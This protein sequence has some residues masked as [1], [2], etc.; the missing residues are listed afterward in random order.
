VDSLGALLTDLSSA[1]ATGDATRARLAFRAVRG[2]YKRNETLLSAFVPTL[3]A[4]FNGPLPEGSDDRPAPPLSAPAA[5]QI[6]EAA[7]FPGGQ[8]PGVESLR[9]TIA[10]M[11]ETI[12][13]FRSLTTYLDMTDV[14]VLDA[15]RLEL[16]R[17]ACIGLAGVDADLS[18]DAVI[19]SA[20][21]LEGTRAVLRAT[22]ESHRPGVAP[23]AWAAIDSSVAAAA[24]YLRGHPRFD[25]LDRLEFIVRY[26]NPASRALARARAQL[27]APPP[28][29]RLWRQ[30]V[31]TVFDE[32]AFDPSAFA[33]DYAARSSPALVALG[34]RLFDDPRLSGPGTR[35]CAFCHDPVRGFADGK[36]RS[37]LLRSG[38]AHQRNTP[39]LID[40][41]YQPALFADSRAG[42]L[43]T[44]VDLVL[45]SPT[46]MGGSADQAAARL[47]A[48]PS[49]REE[50]ARAF[51]GSD[52]ALTAR[53]LRVAVA[54][55]VRSLNGLNSP[56][57]RAL[58]GD[59]AALSEAAHRGFTLF[60]GKARC[61]TCHFLPLLNGTLPP[62]FVSSEPEIIGVTERPL[63]RH[64]RLDPDPGRGGVDNEPTHRGAF[65]VP[66][67]RNISRTAPYMHNG[68][69]QCLEDVVDFYDRG[70][71]A[72][73]GADVPGQT[74]P[75]RP[76]HLSEGEK[77]DL[78]AFL[79]SLDDSI[80]LP[81]Q[82]SALAGR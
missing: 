56:F 39:T 27:P 66:T 19:E 25:S 22:G 67:L 30:D 63:S 13:Y 78:I 21:A 12:R 17:V 41:A 15:A 7:L 75:A 38:V 61:G 46:E 62:D 34:Q 20:E 49:Y 54:A 57:D 69:F 9:R 74:L 28:L 40:A 37:E 5:F 82:R 18:G 70:G 31:A 32:G 42:S 8:S 6:L 14:A 64:A 72:G 68:A 43:E 26:A 47:R 80:V 48:D 36:A 59:T 2:A 79:R 4:T 60:M 16:A 35:S 77:S 24:A 58:R 51:P 23:A 50:F 76:L 10:T 44:Q 1:I 71:G 3:A 73:S 55:F 29:R 33:P 53:S 81:T 52:S 11:G 65:K 45:K